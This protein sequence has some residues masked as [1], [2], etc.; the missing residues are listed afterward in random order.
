MRIRTGLLPIALAVLLAGC[1]QIPVTSTSNG[2]AA[3]SAE[4]ILAKTTQALAKAGSYTISGSMP[5]TDFGDDFVAKVGD[6]ISYSMAV[7]GEDVAVVS[8]EGE[9]KIEIRKVGAMLYLNV[10]MEIVSIFTG[11]NELL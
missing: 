11:G 5:T 6:E 2:V 10:P 4:E 1:T 8:G 3:L 7:T 9:A